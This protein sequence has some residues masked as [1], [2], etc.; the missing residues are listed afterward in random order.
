MPALEL[1]CLLSCT[2]P[3]R[4]WVPS[5][6]SVLYIAAAIPRVIEAAGSRVPRG[7]RRLAQNH[8]VHPLPRR[9]YLLLLLRHARS[10]LTPFRAMR[11]PSPGRRL[12]QLTPRR[13]RSRR[14][15]RDLVGIWLV[16]GPSVK[17]NGERVRMEKGEATRVKSI[18]NF[19]FVGLVGN[20]PLPLNL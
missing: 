11:N 4:T 16:A 18:L 17:W 12:P 10:A 19:E 14:S 8:Q 6:F 1:S 9:R 5:Q 2:L 20:K 15:P 13:P 7:R 3:S